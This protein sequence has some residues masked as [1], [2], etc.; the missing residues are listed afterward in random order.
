M[1]AL[2]AFPA[3]RLLA[4]AIVSFAV[5]SSPCFA[6]PA[7]FDQADVCVTCSAANTNAGE[8]AVAINPAN[9]NQIL[10][11]ANRWND[12]FGFPAVVM[13]ATSSDGG[14]SW[15]LNLAGFNGSVGS[16]DPTSAID[17]SNRFYAGFIAQDPGNSKAAMVKSTSV[18]PP[19]PWVRT[20]DAAAAPVGA[21]LDKPHAAIHPSTGRIHYAWAVSRTDDDQVIEGVFSADFGVSWTDVV[22]ISEDEDDP[23]SNREDFGVNLRTGPGP[24]V[25][26]TW[27]ISS[28]FGEDENALGFARSVTAG[29]TWPLRTRI[30]QVVTGS[31][32]VP[33]VV[34]GYRGSSLGIPKNM[35]IFSN[36]TMAVDQASG[37]IYIVWLNDVDPVTNVSN[38]FGIWVIKSTNQGSTWQAPVRVNQST[39]NDR[40]FPWIVWDSATGALVVAYWDSRK[41]TANDAADVF[42]S[43]SWDGGTTWYDVKVSDTSGNTNFSGNG[44]GGIGANG[45]DYLTVDAS[46]GIAVVAWADDRLRQAGQT[47]PLDNY[48]STLFLWGPDEATIAAS[49]TQ[50]ANGKLDVTATWTTT[51][52]AAEADSLIL[53]PPSGGNPIVARNLNPPSGINH[54][55]TKSN[56]ACEPGNWTYIVKSTRNGKTA[57]SAT[58][59]FFVPPSVVVAGSFVSS[60]PGAKLTCPAGG[61][62]SRFVTSVDFEGNCVTEITSN[63]MTLEALPMDQDNRK[64]AFFPEGVPQP[65]DGPASPGG[66]ATTITE[67]QVGGCNGGPA[68]VY[69]DAIEM[70][71]ITVPSHPSVDLNGSGTVDATDLALISLSLGRCA[72][73]PGY[74]VC[75]DYIVDPMNCVTSSELANLANHMGHS[76]DMPIPK[77]MAGVG[78]VTRLVI[79]PSPPEG[80][81]HVAVRLEGMQTRSAV[82]VVLRPAANKLQ[83]TAWESE[84]GTATTAFAFAG[85]DE[86]GARLVLL[87]LDVTPDAAGVVELGRL[88]FTAAA[89]EVV[90][91]EDLVISYEDVASQDAAIASNPERKARASE[92][93]RLTSLGQNYP[94]PCNPRTMIRYALRQDTSVRLTIYD[95]AGRAVRTLIDSAMQPAGEHAVVW[96]GRQDSGLR[97]SSGIYVYRLVTSDFSGTRKLVLVQ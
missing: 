90:T 22:R 63:R 44:P 56:I 51:L 89:G 27:G 97:S 83:F 60:D 43:V 71:S 78:E 67:T 46:D 81:A 80:T 57:R 2:Q 49:F 62:L 31:G 10:L 61:G 37:A 93:P 34:R 39:T 28:A 23:N 29:L 15:V 86:Q 74:D 77:A 18:D 25:Y 5:T 66:Y 17:L 35:L 45:N 32:T 9:V 52:N 58:R 65:A 91:A 87:V 6:V 36:P 79:E 30:S 13:T 72:G 96:D 53:F 16:L 84:P 42:V 68:P 95:V 54:S 48:I 76:K 4:M 12:Q 26:G 75:A 19:A 85:A 1:S 92:A 3:H 69:L 24:E 40:W 21:F 55:L 7:L 20:T 73:S 88:S 64:I 14:I 33:L 50:T 59:S 38:P 47:P 94:N 8:V 82:A 11:A 70:A 41:Y